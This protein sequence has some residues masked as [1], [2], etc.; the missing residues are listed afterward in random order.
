MKINLSEKAKSRLTRKQ[1]LLERHLNGFMLGQTTSY[2]DKTKNTIDVG[3][4]NG[5][6]SS[7]FVKHSKHVYAFEA[8]EPVFNSL[9]E[10][11]FENNNFTAYNLA[12]SNFNGT[13]D[14][15]VDLRRLSNSS[16][17]NHVNGQLIQVKTVTLDS[18]NFDN[19]GFLKIDVEGFELNVLEG[20]QG[21]IEQNKPT[22]MIEI[23]PK[24][25]N[26]PVENTFDFMFERKYN[27]YY[28]IKGKGLKKIENTQ[29]GVEVAHGD[30]NIHD[31]DFLFVS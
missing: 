10:L 15:Y 3:G 7:Y 13:S 4:R 29:Q 9:K 6:Y 30:I 26:G 21:L 16:F 19:V 5:L 1:N 25:N 18:M 31:G 27:C 14:F 20:A 2:L 28:N 22:C 17:T 23:Y 11:E 12:V 24:F 8:V